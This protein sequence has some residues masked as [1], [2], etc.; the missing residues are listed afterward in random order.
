V[1]YLNLHGA[2]AEIR[3]EDLAYEPPESA[4]DAYEV[5]ARVTAAVKR[6]NDDL[7]IVELSVKALSPDPY[8]A[9]AKVK[10]EGSLV[11]VT[12]LRASKG[13]LQLKLADGVRGYLAGRD[14]ASYRVEDLSEAV[15][16]GGVL[17]ACILK[18]NL[19]KSEAQLSTHP[20]DLAM[21][22]LRQDQTV[23]GTVQNT[24][25]GTVVIEFNG[26]V[27]GIIRRGDFSH[28]PPDDLASAVTIGQTLSAK[29]L[30][31]DASKREVRL[32]TKA[33]MPPAYDG[34]KASHTRGQVV[35]A[36]V[37]RTIQSF[38]FVKLAGGADGKIHVSDLAARRVGHPDEI[39]SIGQTIRVAIVDF[40][41]DRR[42]VK[43]SLR[44][45][46]T[47]AA[48]QPAPIAP[49]RP[50]PVRSAP[51]TPP[52]QTIQQAATPKRTATR[53]GSSVESAVETACRALRLPKTKVRVEVLDDGARGMFGRVKRQAKVRVTE[54]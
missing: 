4:K 32:S 42:Q 54:L 37:T 13:A 35:S 47:G 46:P 21:G 43:L 6:L 45:V 31:I 30:E 48:P 19:E 38:V 50:A 25:K 8:I 14:F 51:A 5:G 3:V 24:T 29:I 39:V 2:T 23:Q 10:P 20:F 40:E 27:T 41:D 26:G 28:D 49:V 15:D 52:R 53:E 22:T 17:Q 9:F 36:K 16:P 34:F 18:H 11:Q 1:V 33:L 44:A 7:R 12:V